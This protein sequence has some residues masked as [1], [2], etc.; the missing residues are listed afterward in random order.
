MIKETSNQ[1][2]FFHSLLSGW[3]SLFHKSSINEKSRPSSPFC[4]WSKR[5]DDRCEHADK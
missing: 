2:N 1:S 3:Q 4:K 5:M